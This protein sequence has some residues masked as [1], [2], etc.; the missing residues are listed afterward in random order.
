MQTAATAHPIGTFC[1]A[2]LVSP[3]PDSALQFY[4]DLFGWTSDEIPG[5]SHPYWLFQIEGQVVAGLRPVRRGRQRR[6]PG[7]RD[8]DCS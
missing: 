3:D 5:P 8:V 1:F 2:E 7:R 6:V 4:G